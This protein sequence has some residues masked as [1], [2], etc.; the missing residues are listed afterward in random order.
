MSQ[1]TAR[2]SVR[3]ALFVLILTGVVTAASAQSQVF[4]SGNLVVSVEG[5]GVESGS[6]VLRG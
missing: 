5:N 4:T 3:L 6:G 2:I 1:A